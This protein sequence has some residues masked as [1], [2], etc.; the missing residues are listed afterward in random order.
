VPAVRPEVLL[1]R[2]K[3]DPLVRN[4]LFLMVTTVLTALLGFV[5]WLVVARLYPV[6]EVGRATSLI[7]AVVLLSYF[8]LVGMNY[9]LVRR[10]PTSTQ[11]SELVG[12][13]FVLVAGIAVIVAL[14]FAIVTAMAAPELGFIT[15]SWLSLG[16]FVVLA[17]GAALSLLTSSIFVALRSA[18]YNLLVNGVL[19]GLVKIALPF[20]LV[21]AGAMGIFVANGLASALA[22]A[23]GL[24]LIH[25]RLR[26]TVRLTISFQIIRDT[27]RFCVGTYLQSALNL[28]P[29][30]LIPILV[31]ERLG[32][33]VAAAYFMAFQIATVINSASFA[34]GESMFAEGAHEQEPLR[35][36]AKRSAAI[37][38]AITAPAVVG[39]VVL[40]GPALRL[41]GEQYVEAAQTA[42]VVLALASFAVAFHAWGSFLLKIT[43][44]VTAMIL[45]EVVFA[46]ATT[47]LVVLAI[48]G[49]PAWVAAAW[50]GGNLVAGVVAASALVA[51][52][53]RTGGSIIYRPAR[54]GMQ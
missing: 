5:F 16:A 42:L 40:A 47:V 17:T 48:D 36:L 52:V 51:R 12:T 49:G 35:A 30:L 11:R 20:L 27:I 43:G 33:A 14:G 7:S 38:A 39:V 21:W 46:V 45:S 8:S 15:D 1:D 25:N 34:I 44:Q 32:P 23:V 2:I 31:L 37:M 41:F 50:G 53:R 4:S 54:R 18:Q 29:Q 6:H 26:I 13:A 10:L 19:L 22:V 9:N 3:R 28:L 24:W